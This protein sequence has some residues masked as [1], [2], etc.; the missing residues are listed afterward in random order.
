LITIGAGFIGC[1][2]AE[3]L[4]ARDFRVTIIDDLST[5]SFENISHLA[6]YS[7]FNFA[8][9]TITN[10]QSIPLPMKQ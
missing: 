1:H 6:D 2:L 9:D 3:A 10:L 5:G 4:L 8:I 7:N